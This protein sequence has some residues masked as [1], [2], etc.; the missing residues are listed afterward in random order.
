MAEPA[1]GGGVPGPGTHIRPESFAMVILLTVLVAHGAISNNMVLPSLPALSNE[2]Q[3]PAGVAMLTISTFFLGFGVGQLFYGSLSDRF[4]RRPVLMGGLGLYTL[5]SAACIWAP[6]IETLIATRLLQGLAAA[7]AQ[8]LARAIVRD[9]FTPIRAAKVLSLMAAAFTFASAFAPLAGGFAQTRLG[10]QG[11][12][13]TLTMVGALTFLVVW[14]RFGESLVER[15]PSAMNPGRMLANYRSLCTSRVFA[16]Y[17]LTFAAAFAG[18]FAFHSGSSFVLITL[19]GFAPET[20]G[21]LFAFVLGGYF[22]GTVFSA[23]TTIKLG[24]YRLVAI[25]ITSCVVSG[26][27]MVALVLAGL[28]GAATILGPQFVFMFGIGI[29]L[30]NAIAGA[31]GPFADKAGAASAL[32]GFTQQ[33]MG[34]AMVALLGGL[35][36]STALPMAGC[37][38]AGAILAL[39]CFTLIVPRPGG[40]RVNTG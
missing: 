20:F 38:F 35:V 9:H 39:A 19:L 29:I 5:A 27:L 24:V 18:M 14:R 6:D 11:V 3:V 36:D 10:W 1:A 16:G 28:T 32:L 2:F 13:M 12:F 4:G 31:L 26:G 33:I 15:D 22:I 7:S 40:S 23:R 21:L 30:P 37:V 17:T 8:V 34:G 25:G